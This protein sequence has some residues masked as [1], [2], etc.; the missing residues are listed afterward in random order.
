MEVN[1]DKNSGL[2]Q[3]CISRVVSSSF[4]SLWRVMACKLVNFL[5]VCTTTIG[6]F[7]FCARDFA[8]G[9]ICFWWKGASH[10]STQFS[11]E[12]QHTEIPTKFLYTGARHHQCRNRRKVLWSSVYIPA[13]CQP[14]LALA[15]NHHQLVFWLKKTP[16]HEVAKISLRRRSACCHATRPSTVLCAA[17]CVRPTPPLCVANTRCVCVSWRSQGRH[18][19]FTTRPRRQLLRRWGRVVGVKVYLFAS[20]CFICPGQLLTSFDKC[21]IETTTLLCAHPRKTCPA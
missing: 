4:H 6:L 13:H 19:A 8:S 21:P 9:V 2:V 12:Q 18:F 1:W 14:N 17:L 11:A 7:S 5:T 15:C 10:A 20:C 16:E 3:Y